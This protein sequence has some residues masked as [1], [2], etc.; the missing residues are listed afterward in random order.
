[1]RITRSAL[2]TALLLASSRL[3]TADILLTNV[4]VYD[5]TGHRKLERL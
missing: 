5:G 1:M 4:V 3:L 2:V